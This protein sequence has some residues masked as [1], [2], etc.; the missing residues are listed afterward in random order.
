MTSVE[1]RSVGKSNPDTPARQVSLPVGLTPR[2]VDWDFGPFLASVAAAMDGL[3]GFEESGEAL[4][5]LLNGLTDLPLIQCHF[6]PAARAGDLIAVCEASEAFGKAV[7]AL[8]AGE[9]HA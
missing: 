4:L 7:A 3:P 5:G 2:I 6:E 9:A 8:R 1:S